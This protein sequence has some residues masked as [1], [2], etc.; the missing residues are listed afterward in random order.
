MEEEQVQL[1]N[2]EKYFHHHHSELS[3]TPSTSKISQ[4]NHKNN[5]NNEYR[6]SD[7]SLIIQNDDYVDDHDHIN[8]PND[9]HKK[10]SRLTSASSS[11]IKISKAHPT[12]KDDYGSDSGHRGNRDDGD[13]Y[14]SDN[15]QLGQFWDKIIYSSVSHFILLLSVCAFIGIGMPII[16]T[17]IFKANT[18]YSV[19]SDLRYQCYPL[20]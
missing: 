7:A 14:N 10:K 18:D 16:W 2:P 3:L 6:S 13:N 17:N 12:S 8:Q 4:T 15:I 11:S 20:R 5:N 9:H 1:R 19:E